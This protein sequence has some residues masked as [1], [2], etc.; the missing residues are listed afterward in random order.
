VIL[1]IPI[2]G[3][4]LSQE[5][6][7]AMEALTGD[8]L[9]FRCEFDILPGGLDTAVSELTDKPTPNLLIVE[10]DTPRDS[11]FEHLGSLANVCDPATKVILIGQHND[12]E[13]FQELIK[14]GISDYLVGP[15][16]SERL[17]DSISKVYQGL[18]ADAE[19]RVVA[20]SGLTGGVGSSIIAHNTAHQLAEIYDSRAMVIDLDICFGTA[21]LNFNIQPRQTVVDA[22][23]Q[24]GRLDDDLL[25]QFF[26]LFEENVSILASPSSLSAGVTVTQ[27]SFDNLLKAIR[28]MGDFIILDLPH[29]WTPWVSDALA[30]ADEVVLVAKPDLTNLRNAKNVIEF[31]GPKRG[32]EAPTR[33]VL[34]QVGISKGADLAAKDFTEAVA[35][36]PSVSIPFEPELFGKALNNGE[37]MLKVGKKNKATVAVGELAKQVSAREVV[38]HTKK[39]S[40]FSIFKKSKS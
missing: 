6:Q 26:M 21:A 14:N 29:L 15:V 36:D 4:P 39:H 10:M 22:L 5:T 9:L 31:I 2:G 40:I 8:R 28:P 7:S 20:F 19:G 35:I 16:N 33:L 3:F 27:D 1:R 32:P 25:D 13:L 37:M 12:I 38:E 23:S 17:R 18:E 34:N 11:F 24:V 30:A